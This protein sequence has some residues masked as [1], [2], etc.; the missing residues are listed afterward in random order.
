MLHSQGGYQS[1]LKQGHSPADIG[2]DHFEREVRAAFAESTVDHG[3][4]FSW[5][6][7]V[8]DKP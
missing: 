4:T 6:A 5:I 2:A 3:L 7:R 1:L 8:G